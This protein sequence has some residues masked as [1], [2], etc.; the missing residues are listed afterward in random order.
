[1]PRDELSRHGRAADALIAS[2]LRELSSDDGPRADTPRLDAAPAANRGSEGAP[3]G[4]QM[5]PTE[6]VIPC[7]LE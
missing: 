4:A 7:A 2:Y 5:Q 1:M 3:P 6:T